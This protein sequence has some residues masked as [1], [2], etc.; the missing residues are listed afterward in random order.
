MVEGP[1]ANAGGHG[2][3]PW[4]GRFH[5]PQQLSPRAPTTEAREPRACALQQE[6]AS[7]REAHTPQ[8]RAAPLGRN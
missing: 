3:D 5:I 2:F 1:T 4:S 7:Q 6:K 8:R